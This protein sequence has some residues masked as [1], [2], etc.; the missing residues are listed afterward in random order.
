MLCVMA[1][2]QQ[3]FMLLV[4]LILPRIYV[5]KYGAMCFPIK[6]SFIIYVGRAFT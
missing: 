1:F 2:I 5:P 4:V 3:S 6:G